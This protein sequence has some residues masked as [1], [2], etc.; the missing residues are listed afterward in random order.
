MA[1]TPVKPILRFVMGRTLLLVVLTA[2]LALPATLSAST[3][4]DGTLSVKRGRGIVLVKFRGTEIGRLAQGKVRITDKTPFDANSPQFRHCRIRHIN[5]STTLCTGRKLTFRA[6]DGRYVVR[7]QGSGMYLS[8]VGQG[9]VMVDGA[10][11]QGVADGV[12]SIDDDPYQSLP[13]YATTFDLG[14]PPTQR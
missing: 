4:T 1:N 10:G 7:V 13:D 9:M 6:T 12:M 5:P 11:D 2:A 8:A 3:A 14:T